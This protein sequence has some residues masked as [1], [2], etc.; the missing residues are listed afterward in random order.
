MGT[1]DRQ[2]GRQTEA[3][4]ETDSQRQKG[5]QT[6]RGREAE[7]QRDAQTDRQTDIQREKARLSST[8]SIALYGGWPAAEPGSGSLPLELYLRPARHYDPLHDAFGVFGTIFRELEWK[9]PIFFWRAVA[10]TPNAS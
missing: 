4:R 6:D 1:R 2:T 7:R 3:E 8:T 9:T 5:R 10:K